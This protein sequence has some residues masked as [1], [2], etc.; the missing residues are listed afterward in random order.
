MEFFNF[1]KDMF[2]IDTFPLMVVLV[3]IIIFYYKKEI[4][5]TFKSYHSELRKD[6]ENVKKNIEDTEEIVNELK[7][8]NLKM[9]DIIKNLLE[10]HFTNFSTNLNEITQIQETIVNDLVDNTNNLKDI[11]K[12]LIDFISK[13]NIIT[14]LLRF[15]IDTSTSQAGGLIDKETSEEYQTYQELKNKFERIDKFDYLTKMR[16]NDERNRK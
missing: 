8:I 10:K 16:E 1:I 6:C 2:A 3:L 11:K 9:E 7:N 12:Y 15:L 4:Y 14:E 13:I 5:P